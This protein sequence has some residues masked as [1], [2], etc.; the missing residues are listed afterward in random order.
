MPDTPPQNSANEPA[1]SA[2][3]ETPAETT[4]NSAAESPSTEATSAPA[5]T[6]AT[7]NPTVPPTENKD[8]D[9]DQALASASRGTVSPQGFLFVVLFLS[10]GLV[11]IFYTMLLWVHL[12]GSGFDIL[13]QFGLRPESLQ[14]VLLNFT[15]IFFIGLSLL[16]FLLALVNFFSYIAHRHNDVRKKPARHRLAIFGVLFLLVLG[17]WIGLYRLLSQGVSYSYNQ[18]DSLIVTDPADTRQLESPVVVTFDLKKKLYQQI[19]S[20]QVLQIAWDLDGNGD[21]KD[22]SND[23]ITYRFTDKGENNGRFNVQAR[24]TYLLD[25]EEKNYVT[26]Q[27]VF[28]ANEKI[29]PVLEADTIRGEAPL[30]VN[31]SAASSRD[32]D[33]QIVFY[34]WDLDEDPNGVFEVRQDTPD[35]THTFTTIGPHIARLR[36]TGSNNDV[37]IIEKEIEVLNP[38]ENLRADIFSLNGF[39]DFVPFR[40]EL[41][42]SRSYV[43]EGEIIRYEWFLEGENEGQIG[44][45]WQRVFREPGE[46]KVRLVVE[47]DLGQKDEAL[48]IVTVLDTPKEVEF[49][50]RSTPQVSAENIIRGTAPLPLTLD[51]SR[52]TI[53]NAVEWE[54]DLGADGEVELKGAKVNTTLQEV[55]E[56]VLLLTIRNARGEVFSQTYN[57]IAERQGVKADFVV[58]PPLGEIPLIVEMDASASIADQ[59]QIVEYLWSF[60]EE[61][62]ISYGAKISHEFRTLGAH[63]IDLKIRTDKEESDQIRKTV[64]VTPIAVKALFSQ[65]LKEDRLVVFNGTLSRGTIKSF[66]WDFGDGTT[67][68]GPQA[69][70]QYQADGTYTVSLKVV[71]IYGVVNRYSKEVL[72]TR[73]NQ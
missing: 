18:S 19:D 34:E 39:S 57:V 21:F 23:I 48:Q 56:Y 32:P 14:S 64:T 31:F 63:T 27:E 43:R 40:I 55:G 59:G 33:G 3:E 11:G 68:S 58:D 30:V 49:N 22:G 73:L 13:A 24:I 71:D 67:D 8:L 72:V 9:P 52:T 25:G 44:K 26:S 1:N 20:D 35:L 17:A 42:G 46:Y 41:D 62:W 16:F 47:N 61:E 45:T 6:P 54:W 5:T 53:P 7:E 15:N 50:L 29:I 36:I 51:A 4:T 37:A 70:H 66:S 10:C 28:I 60:D 38:E 2:P 65:D 69:S 12:S